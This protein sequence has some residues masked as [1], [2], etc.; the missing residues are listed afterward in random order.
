MKSF[1]FGILLGIFAF[2]IAVEVAL[3]LEVRP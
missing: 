2:Y 1:Q 3:L